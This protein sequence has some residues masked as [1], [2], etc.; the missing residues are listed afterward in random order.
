MEDSYSATDI[1]FS[2]VVPVYNSSM[3]LEELAERLIATISQLSPN[4]E[5]IFVDDASVDNSWQA[6]HDLRKEHGNCIRGVR[7]SRN[8][9]QH[10]ATLCGLK[11]TEGKFVIT[12]DD[13]L[14]F[15]PEDILKL[16]EKQRQTNKR[17]VYGIDPK[18]KMGWMRRL[19]TSVFRKLEKTFNENYHRGSSFRLMEGD[20]ARKITQHV[21]EFSFVDEYLAWYTNS[22]DFVLIKTEKSSLTSRYRTHR[23]I[24]LTKDLIYL[25]SAV[26]LT[27]ATYSGFTIMV[28]NFLFGIRV[29]YKR[30][31]LKIDVK[32]YTS[33]IVAILFSTGAIIFCLGIIAEYLGKMLKMNYG[34]PPYNEVDKIG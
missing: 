24:D 8:Y 28:I 10:N 29:I 21:R 11:H 15:S 19:M 25:S 4:F 13:D 16:V 14:E 6:I 1:E 33:L 30:L 32:G 2:V 26:P 12:I 9:G 18:K 27:I 23:L 31:F 17:V 5:L 20:L 22:F 7:L 34:K 3:I